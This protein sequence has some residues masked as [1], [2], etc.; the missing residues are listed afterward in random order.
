LVRRSIIRRI[1][2]IARWIGQMP[3][4]EKIRYAS[5]TRSAAQMVRVTRDLVASRVWRMVTGQAK[6][7]R[8]KRRR[9]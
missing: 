3:E 1:N 7:N 4:F 5:A 2:P 8:A 6:M 9:K